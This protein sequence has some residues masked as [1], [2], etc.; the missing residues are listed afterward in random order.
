MTVLEMRKR[1]EGLEAEGFADLPLM[2][3]VNVQKRCN[4][5]KVKIEGSGIQ[6]SAERAV[7]VPVA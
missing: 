7:I 3:E 6:T 5:E 1:L 2:I 4:L